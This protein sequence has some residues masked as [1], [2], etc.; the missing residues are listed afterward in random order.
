LNS[1][2]LPVWLQEAKY[3]S[4]YTGK[5]FNAHTVNN[6]NA[7]YPA[8]F[9]GSDFLLDPHTYEYLNAS[10]QRN[11]QPPVS[12]EGRYSTDVLADKAYGFLEDAVE[13]ERPFFLTIAPVAPHSNV[14]FARALTN[15]SIERD[16]V[17]LSPP[18]PAERHRNLFESA[19]VPRNAN[20][21]PKKV[22]SPCYPDKAHILILCAAE[23]C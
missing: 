11:Q 18:I 22:D 14:K 15:G 8:G 5:L 21:N 12:Y 7:P 16:D 3:N 17:E 20:F 2:Y 19:V 4:Y 10:F 9:N 6:Y 23:R 1:A 13:S